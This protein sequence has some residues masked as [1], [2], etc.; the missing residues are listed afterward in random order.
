MNTYLSEGG[1]PPPSLLFSTPLCSHGWWGRGPAPKL[2]ALVGE[3]TSP[4]LVPF[5]ALH[6]G[7]GVV[8][9]CAM[10]LLPATLPT[11]KTL[12]HLSIFY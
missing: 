5:N 3:G 9:C 11:P 8:A 2:V 10:V 1:A 6:H 7:V 12:L 4:K